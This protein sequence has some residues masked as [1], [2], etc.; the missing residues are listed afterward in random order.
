VIRSRLGRAGQKTRSQRDGARAVRVGSTGNETAGLLTG[1]G[2]RGRTTPTAREVAGS[3]VRGFLHP[4]AAMSELPD[5]GPPTAGLVAVVTRFAV[6]D[7]VQTLP[8]ALLGR[9]PFMPSRLPIRPEHHYRAQVVFLPFFGVIQWLLM[10]AAAQG[11]LRLTGERSDLSRVLDVIGQGM[12]SPMPPL[13][14][15]DAALIATD[16]FRLPELAVVNPAVQ[17][18]ETALFG[19]GT[20]AVLKVSWPRAI[21]AGVAASVVYVVGASRFLR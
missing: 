13:W 6:Q 5:D 3:L 12:L 7:L 17:R 10:G 2:R 19:V 1:A 14:L 11:V 4:V 15:C 18:C 16:R 21:A 20:R 8:L 9:R